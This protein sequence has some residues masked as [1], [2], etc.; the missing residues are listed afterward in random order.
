MR[1]HVKGFPRRCVFEL[2]GKEGRVSRAG[3]VYK[4]PTLIE[5]GSHSRRET[6]RRPKKDVAFGRSWEFDGLTEKVFVKTKVGRTRVAS[7]YRHT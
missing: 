7:R 6:P 1:T 4:G 3:Q 2:E 5:G